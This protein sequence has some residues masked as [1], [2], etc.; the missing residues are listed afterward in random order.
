VHADGQTE[1]Q[2]DRQMGRARRWPDRDT[3]LAR[4]KQVST[5]KGYPPAAPATGGMQPWLDW[6]SLVPGKSTDR[7]ADRRQTPNARVAVSVK[8]LRMRQ[9]GDRAADRQQTANAR[10]AVS[11]KILRMRNKG[12]RPER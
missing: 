7:A 12:D 11:E 6:Q 2:T 4:Q 3:G 10:V 9:K 8:I 1:R 5:H